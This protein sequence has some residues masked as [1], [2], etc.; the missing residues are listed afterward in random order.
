VGFGLRSRVRVELVRGGLVV[1][2]EELGLALLVIRDRGSI[3]AASRALGVPYSRLWERLSRAERLLGVPL[4]EARRGGSGGGGARLTRAGL[5]VLEE[6]VRAYRRVHGV[7]PRPPTA[8]EPPGGGDV[9]VY[10]GSSDPLLERVLGE[11]SESG[12]RVEAYWLGSLRGAASVMLGDADVAGVHIPD[13]LGGD[14]NVAPLRAAVEAGHHA[15]LRGYQR[16]IGLVSRKPLRLREA[17]EGLLAG[18]LRL[19]NRPPGSGSRLL[20]ERLLRRLP[21]AHGG[22]L[23]GRVRGWDREARTHLEVA[24]AVARGKADVGVAVEPAARLYGLSFT[25]IAWEWFDL[26]LARWPP[27]PGVEALLGILCSKRLERLASGIPGYRLAG[28][29]CGRLL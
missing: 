23:A 10:A 1:V 21:G 25:P 16:R 7:H 22:L 14:Y 26:L 9:V 13:P 18:R 5:E 24:E 19:I 2:D 6:F 28:A 8:P 15:L 12:V 27:T 17:L 29:R 20:L 11:V 3:L 4:V